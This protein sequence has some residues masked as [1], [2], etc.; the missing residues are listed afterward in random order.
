M[1][2]RKK[3]LVVEDNALNRSLLCQILRDQYDVMEAENGQKALAVLKEYGEG[4]SL[5]LLDI[6][7]P[8]MDGY[9]FLSIVKADP[10]YSSIPVIV[11]TQ[12]DAE[13]DEVAALSHGATDFVAKPYK[14]QVI[15][16]RAAGIIKLRET[17]AMVNLIQYDRLTG[18]YS[19]EY[20]YEQVRKVLLCNPDRQ[21]DLI[22]SDI[23]NFKLINDVFGVKTG[24]RLLKGIGRLYEERMG[25]RAIYGRLGSDRFACFIEHQQEYTNDTFVKAN[26]QVNELLDVHNIVIKW[27]I[28]P[29]EDRRVSVEQM[30]DRAILSARSMKGRYGKYFAVYD[31][32]LRNHLL[33]EQAITDSMETALLENQ[34]LV[35]FQP[36]YR[37][38]GKR[39]IGA[40]ALVRWNHPQWGLLSPA[41]F[42]PL[43]EKNGFITK[44]DQYVWNQACAALRSWDEQGFNPVSVSVNVSRADIYNEDLPNVLENIVKFYGLSPS[45]LHLE[46]TETAYTVNSKQM[47]DTV[48]RLQDQGF[49]IE[50]DDFGSG[51]SSLNMLCDM[52]IDI[53]KLDISFIH[54]EMEKPKSQGILKFIIKLARWM[55]LGV[56]AEGVE[57]EEQL[58][59]LRELGCDYV[60]GYYFAMPMPSD[61]FEAVLKEDQRTGESL[62][63][64]EE[65][66]EALHACDVTEDSLLEQQAGEVCADA[67]AEVLG[68]RLQKEKLAAALAAERHA[69]EAKSN[70]LS[71]ISHEIRTPMNA[72][73]GMSAIAAQSP[74]N[75]KQMQ[76]CILKIGISSRFLLALLND[77]LD[78][79]RIES[80]KMVLK[81]EKIIGDE[82]LKGVNSICQIQAQAKGVEYECIPDPA[83]EATYLGDGMRLEQVLVNLV[84]N[85]IK[86]TEKKGKVTLIP[87]LQGKTDKDALL[88][89]IVKDTG[90]GMS[91]DF[92]SHI[93]E[94]FAQEYTGS[95]DLHGGA[96]L[97]LAIAKSIV[98]MMGGSITVRS[99]KGKGTE[100][101]VEVKLGRCRAEEKEQA[102]LPHQPHTYDFTGRR[103]LLAEDNMINAEVALLLLKE[104]GF[105]ADRAQ[106]G[107]EAL[108]L[109][110]KS[111]N[112]Y[113][114]AVLMDIR[115]PVMDGL[116]AARS[117]RTLPNEDA[118]SIPII[119]M[120]A[121]AFEEDI[122]KSMEAGMNA[123]LAKPI[124]PEELFRT[125]YGFI[126]G[127][128]E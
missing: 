43:F 114:D 5:I 103:V 2:S 94:P 88:R 110:A 64:P 25:S 20:F 91:E 40:E 119:A 108:R 92:I 95:T 30:C 107:Q 44:L 7:M 99:A 50:M 54:N 126:Y 10:A 17:A 104:K 117:I 123:H 27:G 55:H 71:R 115:M 53:L 1:F 102:L 65:D 70:F 60:Q 22:C 109:F 87:S 45:R 125:L 128:K 9:T 36:K 98:D 89:F 62:C 57:T 59:R 37:I 96:G 120:T 77:I 28:Y 29:V 73:I 93:F 23:E 56:V 85:A 41:E 74:G 3:I 33:K 21:Y 31:D 72:I 26:A 52:P 51:Y 82:F 76:D 127:R 13:S 81:N 84:S 24:D 35:W 12:N 124:E 47:T 83:L 16:H 101:T 19:K 116:S 100:F 97:G 113:Y 18:L 34:F 106:N 67:P 80:G 15:L 49:M 39:L 66:W 46:I 6:I 122:K 61:D 121:N 79:S 105:Q 48:A 63:F 42:I 68:E 118:G 112:G 8:V 4:I 111:G 11:T 90:V 78:M 86:F 38:L 69:N 58:I 32:T 14:P 75:E